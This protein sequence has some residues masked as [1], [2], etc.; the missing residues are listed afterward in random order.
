MTGQRG[1]RPQL[2][3]LDEID[4]EL[5]YTG[6]PGQFRCELIDTSKS[7]VNPPRCVKKARWIGFT[8]CV[9]RHTTSERVC[10]EHQYAATQ[11]QAW[12][13]CDR[14]GHPQYSTTT[15]GRL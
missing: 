6:G 5:L 1:L 4:P 9:N 11:G 7:I 14:C 13:K 10:D 8:T 12:W 3:V 15:W 2:V